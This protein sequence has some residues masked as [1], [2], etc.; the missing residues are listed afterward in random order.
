M[1]I[2]VVN[3]LTPAL[4]T[5]MEEFRAEFRNRDS[6]GMHKFRAIGSGATAT[7]YRLTDDLVVRVQTNQSFS[8]VNHLTWVKMSTSSRS[9]HFPRYLYAAEEG[10]LT[11]T[12]T[13]VVSV[14]EKL[15]SLD[16]GADR[17]E[18]NNSGIEDYLYSASK[19]L[20]TSTRVRVTRRGNLAGA[21]SR[22]SIQRVARKAKDAELAMVDVHSSNVMFRTENGRKTLVITDPVI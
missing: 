9:R 15:E 16:W 1:K 10:D 2:V 19:G 21:Y 11:S 20:R 6:D 3:K 5:L 18:Y 17:S 13:V 7:V 4:S 22:D 14:M 8:K 12:G